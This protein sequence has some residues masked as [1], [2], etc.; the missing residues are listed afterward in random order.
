M[1]FIHAYEPADRIGKRLRNI[2]SK[3]QLDEVHRLL[4]QFAL[5]PNEK[6]YVDIFDNATLAQ[7][8]CYGTR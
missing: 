2:S 5:L 7:S 8:L 6:T 1:V 3:R 4:Q